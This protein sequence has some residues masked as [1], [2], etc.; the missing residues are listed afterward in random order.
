MSFLHFYKKDFYLQ[1]IIKIHIRI[2][3]TYMQFK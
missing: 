1:K 3:L 2:N